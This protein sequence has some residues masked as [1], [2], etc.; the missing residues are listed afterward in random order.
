MRAN[1]EEITIEGCLLKNANR[2]GV[3]VRTLTGT[4]T[5]LADG[6]HVLVY[7]PGGAG[8]TVKLWAS[9]QE[10]DFVILHNSA[11]AA[12]VITVQD[13]AAAALTPACTPTQSETAFI[14]YA[15]A[16]WRSFVALGA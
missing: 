10:G 4:T 1:L 15:G 6:A 3:D 2:L 14:V 13:S 12:E 5:L 16:A 9:P 7:D 8:R 11:D